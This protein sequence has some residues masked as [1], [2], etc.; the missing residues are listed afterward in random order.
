MRKIK[1][2]ILSKAERS[3]GNGAKYWRVNCAAAWTGASLLFPEIKKEQ[4]LLLF[5][6]AFALS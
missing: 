2:V 3:G 5:T 4:K 1:G 6:C